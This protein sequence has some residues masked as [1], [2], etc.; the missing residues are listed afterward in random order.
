M[1]CEIKI[2]RVRGP[3]TGGTD[4]VI[5]AHSFRSG[6]A[7]EMGLRG[8]SDNEIMDKGDGQAMLSKH[9]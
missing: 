9:I 4:G 5:R 3:L 7:S 8:F 1:K 6:V 2:F